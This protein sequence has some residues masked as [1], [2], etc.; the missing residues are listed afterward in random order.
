MHV[1]SPRAAVAIDA[2]AGFTQP[3]SLVPLPRQQA[4]LVRVLWAYKPLRV[5]AGRL[6]A[7]RLRRGQLD[8]ALVPVNAPGLRW[9]AASSVLTDVQAEAW[10]K[11]S[12]FKRY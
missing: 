6:L 7:I 11:V 9:V 3:L 1:I 2:D 8:V 5:S 10:V 12:R 4:A